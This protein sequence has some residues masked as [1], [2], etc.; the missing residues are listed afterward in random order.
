VEEVRG[1]ACGWKVL[2]YGTRTGYSNSYTRTTLYSPYYPNMAYWPPERA[3]AE[4]EGE[5]V[6][7]ARCHSV[8]RF[9]GGSF[10]GQAASPRPVH[11]ANPVDE[12]CDCGFW[13][14]HSFEKAAAEY[15]VRWSYPE[16]AVGLCKAREAE[17]T[18]L[19]FLAS[20]FGDVETWDTT[21]RAEYIQL[22]AV[23]TRTPLGEGVAQELASELGIP[24]LPEDE[25]KAMALFLGE[26]LEGWNRMPAMGEN[27]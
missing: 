18:G 17:S 15:C 12:N 25:I 7:R 2:R 3:S 1:S 20:V 21:A 26:S 23:C 13:I 9:S 6:Y 22:R 24:A 27:G 11:G 4:Y 8:T 16:H 5:G 14:H 19:I 10:A